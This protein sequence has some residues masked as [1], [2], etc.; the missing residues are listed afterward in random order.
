MTAALTATVKTT[1]NADKGFTFTVTLSNGTTV[2]RRA[3]RQYAA[4]AFDPNTNGKG[5]CTSGSCDARRLMSEASP[6]AV[7]VDLATGAVLKQP[8]TDLRP[9]REAAAPRATRTEAQQRAW[10]KFQKAP[11]RVAKEF[12]KT[13]EFFNPERL[14]ERVESPEHFTQLLKLQVREL[15]RAELVEALTTEALLEHFNAGR[16]TGGDLQSWA[17]RLVRN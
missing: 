7:V 5:C 2:R 13:A 15:R 8:G 4:L 6:S 14:P 3:T 1:G 17:E 10:E 11:A 9:A 12:R 16:R